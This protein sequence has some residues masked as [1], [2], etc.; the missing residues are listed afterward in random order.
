[1]VYKSFGK[2]NT[3]IERTDKLITINNKNGFKYLLLNKY[4]RS[5]VNARLIQ[6]IARKICNFGKK[7]RTFD[8]GRKNEITQYDITLKKL[9]L[10]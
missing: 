3:I 2:T 8:L 7:Y 4:E 9:I 1:M 5:N 6:I 10:Q